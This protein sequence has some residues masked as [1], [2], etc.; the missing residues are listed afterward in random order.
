ML[1]RGE[2]PAWTVVER[3]EGRP[4][5]GTY[6]TFHADVARTAQDDV[7]LRHGGRVRDAVESVNALV[8]ELPFDALQALA[9]EDAVQYVEPA[10]PSMDTVNAENRAITGVDVVQQSYGLD[11]TGVSVLVYDAG[12]ARATHVDFGGRLT[13]RDASGTNFHS[14]HAQCCR[15]NGVAEVL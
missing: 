13:V 12:T 11:G 15:G 1:E 9:E 4:T 2:V 8:V 3:K 14:T 5:V 7:I 6:V 10:L